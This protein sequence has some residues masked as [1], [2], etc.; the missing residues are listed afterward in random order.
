MGDSILRRRYILDLLSLLFVSIATGI[1]L[2]FVAWTTVSVL[3][4]NLAE[5]IIGAV[6][7]VLLFLCCSAVTVVHHLFQSRAVLYQEDANN[8]EHARQL[9][10]VL[11]NEP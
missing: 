6:I 1:I 2:L 3:P 5:L 8:W 4:H 10:G 11:G 7:A 9:K